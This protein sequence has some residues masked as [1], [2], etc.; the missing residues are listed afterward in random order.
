MHESSAVVD[1]LAV[2]HRRLAT[3][4]WWALAGEAAAVL[5][6]PAAMDIALPVLPMMV[7]VLLQVVVNI[8]AS[9]RVRRR[10][11]IAAAEI[12]GQL[13][14]DVVA[15][16]V[17]LFLSGGATNPLVSLLLPPV[18]VAALVLPV[19]YAV[20]V[21][22]MAIAA[23]SILMAVF[24]PL[25]LA[26][27]ARATSL[28]LIGMWIT[29]VLSAA[30]VSWLIVRM[31][32]TLRQRDAALAA[33]R[34]QALRDERVVALGA[35]AAG[36][37]HELGTPLATIAVIAGE[38][39]RDSSLG[40]EARADVAVLRGQVTACKQIITGLAERAGAGRLEG[41][42]AVRVDHWL[43]RL[44][45]RWQGLRPQAHSS[46]AIDGPNPVP[47]IVADGALEQAMLNLFN[48]A[49]DAGEPVGIRG[50]WD[51]DSLAVEISDNGPGFSAAVLAR[52]GR[53]PFPARDGGAGIGL[54]L[55]QAAVSRLSGRL[56]LANRPQGGALARIELPLAK[57]GEAAP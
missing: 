32:A 55:V 53:E 37:A 39:E 12:F 13:G 40:A 22:A 26:D 41:A 49:A 11:A 45:E 29:F 44:R 27:P 43:E 31:T 3:L 57:A 1:S 5:A 6:A 2:T 15:L 28:H 48:N 16:S 33:A 20:A 8:I 56:A 46:L 36:A 7:V 42:Q 52:A 25:P 51:A 50:C 30:M 54:F 14:V 47:V 21:T 23:Y 18:A 19:G 35:L 24:I 10:A 17:L 38:L 9:L 34:E 4:R